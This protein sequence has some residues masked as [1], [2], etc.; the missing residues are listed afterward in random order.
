MSTRALIVLLVATIATGCGPACEG[1]PGNYT[2]TFS[3][4]L[5][6]ILGALISDDGEISGTYDSTESGGSLGGFV[7]CGTADVSGTMASSDGTCMGTLDGTFRDGFGTGTW[8]ADCGGLTAT[9][10]WTLQ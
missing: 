6:G 7:D 4:D 1:A 3:G 8:H 5:T 2:G 9:G 10:V